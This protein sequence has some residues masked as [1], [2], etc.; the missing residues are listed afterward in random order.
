MASLDKE[1]KIIMLKGEKGQDGL[2]SYDLAV[3]ELH[4]SGTLEEWIAS[5]STPENYITRDEF[6]KVTQAEYDALEQ[7]HQLIPDCYYIITDDETY[8]DLIDRIEAIESDVDDLQIDNTQN[9]SDIETLQGQVAVLQT[10]VQT[11]ENVLQE[12]MP[13][14]EDITFTDNFDT[15][16]NNLTGTINPKYTITGAS[17]DLTIT[18]ETS[19]NSIK[20]VTIERISG[21]NAVFCQSIINDS[22]TKI[23]LKN[24]YPTNQYDIGVIGSPNSTSSMVNYSKTT[25][26]TITIKTIYGTEFTHTFTF[27][28]KTQL[29][30]DPQ[31]N[32]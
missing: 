31:E 13:D 24:N 28:Y 19:Y 22:T 3:E 27:N 10:K 6:K 29:E 30:A 17:V 8:D 14:V 2:S 11:L 23:I 26:F 18:P 16:Y 32:E 7:A 15:F 25:T 20:E 5:F 9:K 21:S 12:I 1:I 4:Y